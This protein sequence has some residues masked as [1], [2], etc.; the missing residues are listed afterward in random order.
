LIRIPSLDLGAAHLYLLDFVPDNL[1]DLK[2]I[3]QQKYP[4]VEASVYA[5]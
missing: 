4:D 2:E 1:S 5:T 3:I